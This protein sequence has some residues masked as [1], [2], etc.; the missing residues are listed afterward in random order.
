MMRDT[1]TMRPPLPIPMEARG[2]PRGSPTSF[3][4]TFRSF[5]WSP[6]LK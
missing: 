2:L 6:W 4:P 5:G 3:P 1:R